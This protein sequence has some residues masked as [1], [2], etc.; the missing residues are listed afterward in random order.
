MGF[1]ASL[2]DTK[3]HMENIEIDTF[4][5]H[6]TLKF[7]FSRKITKIRNDRQSSLLSSQH[8]IDTTTR[9]DDE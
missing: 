2:S 1:Y 3:V 8:E 4:E 5:F 9:N 7:S 6:K